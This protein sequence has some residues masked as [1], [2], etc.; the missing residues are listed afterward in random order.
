MKLILFDDKYE[1]EN[2]IDVLEEMV[3]QINQSVGESG[4]YFSHL[5]VDGVNIYQDHEVY[6]REKIESIQEVVVKVK[7]EKEM[8]NDLLLSTE[9][10]VANALP[11]IEKLAD[12]FYGHPDENTWNKFNQFLEGV[13]WLVNMV[14]SIDKSNYKL[15]T[16]DEF[17]VASSTIE[18]EL[19]SLAE[20]LE[21]KD[22]ILIADIIQY[23]MIPAMKALMNHAKKVIDEQGT[24]P[25]LS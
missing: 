17:F 11:E 8:V 7:S 13:Q 2:H 25:D 24:R 4:Y 19:K 18:N 20:A 15:A 3:T 21:N 16:G 5:I 12:E 14:A 1:Y 9:S 23:E 6:M 10:Y 22:L